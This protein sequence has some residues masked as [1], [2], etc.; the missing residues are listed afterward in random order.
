MKK[1]CIYFMYSFEWDPVKNFTNRLN[2]G[3]DFEDAAIVFCGV[4]V[5]Y[6]DNRKHYGEIRWR[7]YGVL[8]DIVVNI[9][10]TIRND[11]IRIIS[12]RKANSRER[13]RYERE[14]KQKQGKTES[15]H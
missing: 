6:E 7:L 1:A 8:F 3:F 2:H 4:T 15:V 13:N 5:T 9:V 11:S 12:M 14:I 10:Y